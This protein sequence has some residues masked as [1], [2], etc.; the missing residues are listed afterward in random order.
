MVEKTRLVRFMTYC[1]VGVPSFLANLGTYQLLLGQFHTSVDLATM[2]GFAVGGQVSF[3]CH[4]RLTFG[5]RHVNLKGWYI[6]WMKFMPGQFLGITLN[7]LAA[8][9]MV[10][11]TDWRP[12]VVFILANA[13]GV[14]G[15]FTWNNL[16]SH[17]APKQAP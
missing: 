16:V 5:D 15:T 3:W 8:S 13:A 14:I 6:R 7:S 17:A 9:S 4:D 2:M 12:S 11:F 10:E 1:A